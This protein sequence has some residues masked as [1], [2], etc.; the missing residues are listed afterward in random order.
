LLRNY[1]PFRGLLRLRRT[2]RTECLDWLLI[3]NRRRLV[4]VWRVYFDRDHG[5]WPHRSLELRRQNPSGND[6]SPA[7]GW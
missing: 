2:V 7:T 4:G 1:A 6:E 3:L 5:E